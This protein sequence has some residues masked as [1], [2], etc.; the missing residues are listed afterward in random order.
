M[1]SNY[2]SEGNI[3]HENV[4]VGLKPTGRQLDYSLAYDFNFNDMYSLK[5]KSILIKNPGHDKSSKSINS[6]FIGVKSDNHK[7]GVGFSNENKNDKPRFSYNFIMNQFN[8]NE[9]NET[10]KLDLNI[11]PDNDN[12]DVNFNYTLNF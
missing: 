5:F 6:N 3:T 10:Y 8:N 4:K 7:I 2:D 1:V 11:D 12:S 9:I